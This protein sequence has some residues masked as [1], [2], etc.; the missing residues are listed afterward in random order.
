MLKAFEKKAN[1]LLQYGPVPILLALV[2]RA[3]GA[4][5]SGWTMLVAWHKADLVTWNAFFSGCVH[6][7]LS[8]FLALAVALDSG[9][10]RS[11]RRG[12]NL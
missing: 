1:I 8:L 2:V 3:M 7:I 11:E 4:L 5:L 9:S 10:M 12:T 6:S